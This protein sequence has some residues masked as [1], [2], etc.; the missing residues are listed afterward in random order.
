MFN[1]KPTKNQKL[2]TRRRRNPFTLHV[3]LEQSLRPASV[4]LEE[5]GLNE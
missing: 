3:N 4:P 5:D 1:I 2:I